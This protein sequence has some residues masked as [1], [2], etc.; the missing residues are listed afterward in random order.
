MLGMSPLM[1]AMRD[2]VGEN[3][4]SILACSLLVNGGLVGV[5]IS[6]KAQAVASGSK[7]A[8]MTP[9][10]REEAKQRFREN[11]RGSGAGT[12]NFFDFP[13]DVVQL[14]YS[15]EQYAMDKNRAI[16]V[17][18]ICAGL[19]LDPMILGLPSENK[20]YN[21]YSEALEAAW[22][23]TLLPILEIMGIQ[24]SWQTLED[25]PEHE[26][27]D[28]VCWDVSKV[29]ALQPDLDKLFQRLDTAF[30]SGWLRRSDARREAGLEVDEARDDVYI[31]DIQAG[32][33]EQSA[34]AADIA[35]LKASAAQRSKKARETYEAIQAEV[36]D[37]PEGL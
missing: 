21:N 20:T 1:G 10:A 37:E 19:G 28:R 18:R 11:T 23:N 31:T 7:V 30:Q 35:K 13:V 27:G 16:F 26:E 22:E 36:A 33:A 3:E 29:R 15:P 9:A 12:P 6:P 2:L 34:K 8:P 24:L 32:G 17:S 4:A 5:A 25:F 14:G